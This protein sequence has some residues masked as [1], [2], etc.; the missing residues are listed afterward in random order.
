MF[1]VEREVEFARYY[2][3]QTGIMI[4][5]YEKDIITLEYTAKS[6]ESLDLDGKCIVLF[7]ITSP[8]AIRDAVQ[9]LVFQYQGSGYPLAEAE[10]VLKAALI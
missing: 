7:V 4:N 8:G 1:T 10:E 3:V 5:K 9:E 2:Q 6:V